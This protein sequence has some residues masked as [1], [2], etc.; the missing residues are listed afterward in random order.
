MD[1]LEH[2]KI[3]KLQRKL[4]SRKT[5][6]EFAEERTAIAQGEFEVGDGWDKG[7]D[8]IRTLLA[9]EREKKEISQGNIFKKILIGSIVFFPTHA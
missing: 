5:S 7:A 9:K 1:N 2:N 6:G 3:D 8:D 4:Y